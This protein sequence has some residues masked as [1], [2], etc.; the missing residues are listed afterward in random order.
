M[1][2]S[3][4][5]KQIAGLFILIIMAS[6]A[7]AYFVIVPDIKHNQK[8]KSENNA[9]ELDLKKRFTGIPLSPSE[10]RLQQDE[11]TKLYD[12]TL[13]DVTNVFM[14]SETQFKPLIDEF[15]VGRK[16]ED[17]KLSV[18]QLK[19]QQEYLDIVSQLKRKNIYLYEEVLG[20]GENSTLDDKTYQ[21][22]ATMFLVREVANLT[23]YHG[24]KISEPDYNAV[25]NK[26]AKDALQFPKGKAPAMIMALPLREYKTPEQTEPYMQEY[27]V[28]IIAK[29]NAKQLAKF[30]TELN[31]DK[32]FLPLDRIKVEKI[33]SEEAKKGRNRGIN[34]G[35]NQVQVTMRISAFLMKKDP[36]KI[37]VK[38]I[39][40]EP[41][42]VPGA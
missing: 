18:S 6:V 5:Y 10:I 11:M 19:F 36:E 26:K 38:A 35:V 14:K 7:F 25:Y 37:K 4:L 23:A 17:W 12:T 27:S 28:E 42:W 1:N 16:F 39:K 24:L 34:Q 3:K 33:G 21:L 41:T 2:L 30:L 32:R 15:D 40:K 22:L 8:Q 9:K 31:A 29:C 20:I 13:K